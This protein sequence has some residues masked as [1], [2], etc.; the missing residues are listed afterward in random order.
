[1]PMTGFICHDKYLDQM[2]KLSDEELGRVLRACM[3]YH[4]D[5]I[6][7]DNLE[8]FESMA[9][10]FIK[11]DI[12]VAEAAYNKKCN[13]NRK[14]RMIGIEQKQAKSTDCERSLTN[15][16]NVTNVNDGNDRQREE[17]TLTSVA[18]NKYNIINKSNKRKEI[19][20]TMFITFWDKYPRKEG[21][22]NA[23]KAFEKINPNEELLG[24]MLNAIEKQKQSAQWNENGGQYIPHPA[25]WLNG[26][27]WE[28]EVMPGTQSVQ[29]KVVVAQDYTQRDYADEDEEAFNRMLQ[30]LGG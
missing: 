18:I 28:D 8:G 14:N 10:D 30:T 19:N 1:M 13:I 3:V 11:S 9:F 20:N 23:L 17:R 6:I 24:I 25:T 21:K 12:D 29:K 27:R 7:A 26:H 15:V 5:G 2:Q 16:T 22:Q 4:R